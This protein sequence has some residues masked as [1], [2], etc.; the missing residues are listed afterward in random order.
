MK[1]IY[2]YEINYFL[3]MPILLAQDKTL[4]RQKV[5]SIIFI[6]QFFFVIL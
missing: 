2:V 5:Y 1:Y 6:L 4:Q 3:K